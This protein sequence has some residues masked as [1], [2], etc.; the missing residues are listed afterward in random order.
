MDKPTRSRWGWV[1]RGLCTL[2]LVMVELLP[3]L[4]W[5]QSRPRWIVL[6]STKTVPASEGYLDI[7]TTPKAI[8]TLTGQENQ[9]LVADRYGKATF[10]KLKRGTYAFKVE[11]EDHQTEEKRAVLIQPGKPTTYR[12]DLKP[13]FSTLV[14][15]LGRQAD[16]D[17]QLWIDQQPIPPA[18]IE[19]REGKVVVKRLQL[20]E[21]VVHE[22]RIE[23]PYH[24]GL[25]LERPI[26]LGECENFVSIE[27]IPLKGALILAGNAG[28]RIYLDGED[29]GLLASSGELRLTGLLPGE[30]RL[31]AELFG[32]ADLDTQVTISPGKEEKRVE[33]RLEPLLETAEIAHAFLQ[34]KE[35]FFPG[36]PDGWQVETARSLRMVGSGLA[37]LKSG[38]IPE[39]LFSIFRNA[40]LIF[41]V[42]E[43]NGAGIGWIARARDLRQF[44]KF[45]LLPSSPDPAQP[46]Q[47]ILS[48]CRDGDCQPLERHPLETIDGAL[49]R[50]GRFRIVMTLSDD[51]IWHCIT[52]QDGKKRP[53]GP[54]FAAPIF[55]RGGVGL[56]G[57]EGATTIVE[58]LRLLPGVFESEDCEVP[59]EAEGQSA[60]DRGEPR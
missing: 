5:A 2:L 4:T 32:F 24:E 27:L 10:A 44:Y 40:T 29:R 36:R 30:Y 58:E 3:G 16:R 56:S 14:L 31:R 46:Y 21:N 60:P 35:Q 41:Q 17:V 43:W 59:R 28:A 26:Q 55:A 37:L 57:I 15:A 13:V 1:R 49:L 51:Q 11:L 23:K 18:Q 20:A 45:E 53:L 34:E 8:V 22:I 12:V 38:T 50:N 6:K 9:R 42:R 54:T 19:V 48:L 47:L 7:F 52:T 25:V 33:I 39:H